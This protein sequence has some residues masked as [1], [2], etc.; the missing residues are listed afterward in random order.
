MVALL[1]I[2]ARRFG[3][4]AR[5][6]DRFKRRAWRVVAASLGM[7]AV[8]FAALHIFGWTIQVPGWR[9]LALL[10]LIIVAAATYFFLGHLFK[11]FELSEFRKAL[12]R[13]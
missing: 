6:D 1:A 10:V 8:L 7:G 12:R 2:G 13:S 5:F 9:Y 4:E 3:D 11:A